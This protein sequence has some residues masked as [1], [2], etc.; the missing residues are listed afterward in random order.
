MKLF[1]LEATDVKANAKVQVLGGCPEPCMA[2]GAELRAVP[3]PHRH[4]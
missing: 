3:V 1:C 4:L 2:V